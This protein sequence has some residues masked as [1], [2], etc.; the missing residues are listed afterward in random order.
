MQLIVERSQKVYCPPSIGLLA[1]DID[2]R[3]HFGKIEEP[4]IQQIGS[5][6]L[7]AAGISRA[8]SSV[9]GVSALTLAVG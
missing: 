3:A 4:S 6:I 1:M 5:S 2:P 9:A 7:T 8:S